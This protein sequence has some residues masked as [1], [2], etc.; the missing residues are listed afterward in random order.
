MKPRLIPIIAGVILAIAAAVMVNVYLA[1]QRRQ[2]QRLQEGMELKEVLVA[3]ANT[4]A[5]TVL[6]APMVEL[7][8]VPEKFAQPY[9][10][11]Q[12]SAA[13]GK[14]T[15]APIAKGE[16]VLATKLVGAEDGARSSLAMATPPGY[17]AVTI[18][19]DPL[20]AVGGLVQPGDRVD[21][22]W[23]AL[24]PR[25]SGSTQAITLT[26]VRQALVL[27][28][29]EQMLRPGGAVSSDDKSSS[30]EAAK[31][32]R[33]GGRDTIPITFAFAPAEM[34]LVL[35]AQEQGKLQLA[36]RPQGDT[37]DMDAGPTVTIEEVRTMLF[38]SQQPA[39]ATNQRSVEVYRGLEKAVVN[40]QESSR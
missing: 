30:D 13:V 34:E 29:N 7:S 21:I 25:T 19:L 12:A 22:L 11:Q 4:P 28:V 1:D 9:A 36:M 18:T 16:Q 10:L 40:V 8:S 17:R 39:T 37:D 33:S 38:G 15:L 32:R 20:A 2:V 26:L 24:V 6:T 14:M 31:T 5:R 35:F 23:T 27:A 3:T